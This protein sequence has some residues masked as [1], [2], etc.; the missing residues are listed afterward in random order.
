MG[1]R[2]PRYVAVYDYTAADDDEVSFLEGKGV[3][4]CDCDYRKYICYSYESLWIE[5]YYFLY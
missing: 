5:S 1:S 4:D 2:G 3:N